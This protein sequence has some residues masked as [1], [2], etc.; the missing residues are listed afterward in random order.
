MSDFYL[1]EFFQGIS[2]LGKQ[3]GIVK[4]DTQYIYVLYKVHYMTSRFLASNETPH[5]G[6]PFTKSIRSTSLQKLKI[7]I[8]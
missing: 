3:S 1:K 8:K 2:L 4:L 7:Y 6:S 5:Y